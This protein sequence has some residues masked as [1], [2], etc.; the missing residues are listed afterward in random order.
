MFKIHHLPI[1]TMAGG[2]KKYYPQATNREKLQDANCKL[3]KTGADN[4]SSQAACQLLQ[5][6]K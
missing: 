6:C 4:S 3:E 5:D 2:Y 1:A